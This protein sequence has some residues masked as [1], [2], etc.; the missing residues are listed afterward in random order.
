M[1]L[2][3]YAKGIVN[4]L[5]LLIIFQSCRYDEGPAISFLTVKK[6]IEGQYHVSKL[7]IDGKDCTKNYQDSCNGDFIFEF[8]NN[9]ILMYNCKSISNYHLRQGHYQLQNNAKHIITIFPNKQEPV[10]S[11]SGY[12]PLNKG[13]TADWEVRKLT[14]TEMIIETTFQNQLYRVEFKE[15]E[16]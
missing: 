8:D 4:A 16:Y 5:I 9:I 11:I 6:R 1:Y 7:N 2:G 13:I 12:G 10:D 3:H 14:N 15:F